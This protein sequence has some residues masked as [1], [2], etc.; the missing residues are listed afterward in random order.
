MRIVVLHAGGLGDLVLVESYLSALRE[1]HPAARLELVCRA[2]VAPMATLYARPP[3]A[4]HTF[5][6][7]PYRWAIPDERAALEARTL[8]HRLGDAP[9]DLFVSAEL[10]A[11]WLSEVLAAAFAPAEAVFADAREARSS[12]VLILLEKLKLDRKRGIVRLAHASGEHE[13][14]RYAR[15]AGAD[16]R[17]NPALRAVAATAPAAELVVFPLGATPV[18][19]WPMRAMGETAQRIAARLG[20]TITLVGGDKDRADIEGAVAAGFFGAEPAI[21]TGSP[22]DMPSVAAR[23]ASAAGYVGIE[24]GLVH[25]AAAYGV[26]GAT[27]YGGG[28]WPVYAPWAARSAG[29]IA[30]IP[31]FGCEWDCA[32]ERPF[33]IEGVDVDGVVAA[34]DAAYADESGRPVVSERDAYGPRE[35]AIFEAAGNVHRAAQRDR[36]ARLAAITRLRDLLGRYARR[37]RRRSRHADV[38]LAS[39]VETTTQTARRLEQAAS[40]DRAGARQVS[41]ASPP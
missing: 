38:L 3:D 19:R 12:D 6:F 17:R 11:T 29:V 37:T 10:R 28:Y 27:V 18:N 39:L 13:L 1:K 36:A 21:V 32:F 2:D 7:N 20:A 23:I 41:G 26:P 30:P 24:T 35:R 15:L 4:V 22:D 8:L 5:D 14:D 25:L 16:A 40:D 34:F 9:A 31:C 33:C